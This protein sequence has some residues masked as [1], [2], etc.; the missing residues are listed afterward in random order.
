MAKTWE[1]TVMNVDEY[2][3]FTRDWYGERGIPALWMQADTLS[4]EYKAT[5]EHQAKLTWE[6]RQKEVDEAYQRGI[7]KVVEW[8]MKES[9]LENT[10]QITID[11]KYNRLF[12]DD[13][14]QAFLK[15]CEK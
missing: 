4:A 15:E 3:R 5:L 11:T 14:W 9:W 12:D 1:E 13:A 2:N 10:G 6:A 7:K 8:I